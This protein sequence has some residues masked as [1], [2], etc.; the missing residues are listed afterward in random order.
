MRNLIKIVS[1]GLVLFVLTACGSV[2]A[3]E[4]SQTLYVICD[5]N[6]TCG[7]IDINGKVVIEPQFDDVGSFLG[8]NIAPVKVG[9]K[10]GYIDRTGEFVVEP[11]LNDAIKFEEVCASAK[12]GDLWG[13]IGPDGKVFLDP[14]Y[15]EPLHFSEGLALAYTKDRDGQNH[16][17]YIDPTG[18]VVI[19]LPEDL[20]ITLIPS[21]SDTIRVLPAGTFSDGV[22]KIRDKKNDRVYFIDHTGKIVIEPQVDDVYPFSEGLAVVE[23][24]GKSGYIDKTG[25]MV[26]EPQFDFAY[27]FADGLAAVQIDGLLGYIDKT[28]EWVVEAQY[29]DTWSFTE[30]LAPVKVDGKWGYI[31]TTGEMVIEPQ[32]DNAYSFS[33]GLAFA[34]RG[35][36]L[37]YI[38][39][40]AKFIWVSE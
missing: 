8:S 5:E 12:I 35:D 38:N 34:Q 15:L 22:S 9:E 39:E 11:I 32:F 10:W 31:D 29:E 16:L 30:G 19:T 18:E 2:N 3:D 24:D 1:F 36:T 14:Q 27:S 13:C 21:G 33:D 28:G 26:I 25:E 23:V 4:G 20:E 17:T 6:N 40:D 7:F 37:G